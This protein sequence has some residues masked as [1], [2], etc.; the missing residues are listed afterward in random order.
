MK[1][2]NLYI[3]LICISISI[4]SMLFFSF[5]DIK[6]QVINDGYGDYILIPAGEF[7]MGDN[8]EEGDTDELPVHTVYLDDYYIGKYEVTNGEYKKF[9]DDGGYSN[10]E[11]WSAGGYGWFKDKPTMWIFDNFDGEAVH[12][13]RLPENENYPVVGLS[14]FEAMAYCSWLSLK[15]GNTF[16]LPTEAE[17]E[18][19]ARGSDEHNLN[20]PEMG[21]QRR[22]PWGDEISSSYTNYLFDIHSENR[23]SKPVG[24]YDGSIRDSLQTFDNSSPYGVYDMSGNVWEWC[25]D[26]YGD[27]Y[28]ANSPL[29]NPNGPVDGI[30]RVVRGGGWKGGEFYVRSTYRNSI[31]PYRNQQFVGFRCVLVN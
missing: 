2:R 25:Y 13:G 12:G 11:F 23:G 5:Q 19:A 6:P 1:I 15:T 26:K 4:I 10:R 29:E 17:W 24:Y 28:Y 3:S 18:K 16:R 27:T 20:D 22:F 8:F 7:R 21:H 14:W 30:T 9:M 31:D